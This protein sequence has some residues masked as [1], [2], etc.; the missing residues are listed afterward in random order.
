MEGSLT[1]ITVHKIPRKAFC[2]VVI[3]IKQPDQ[4]WVGQCSQCG[5]EFL[6]EKDPKFEAQVYAIRN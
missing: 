5:E 4:S 1:A 2:G 3:L 6:V